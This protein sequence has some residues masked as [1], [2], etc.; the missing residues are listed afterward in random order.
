MK[1]K[2]NFFQ[3][4]KVDS[5]K[6]QSIIVEPILLCCIYGTSFNELF[7]AIQ[8]ISLSPY[9]TLKEYLFHLINYE[10]ILYK[11]QRKMYM[12]EEADLI[13]LDWITME[14]ENTTIHNYEILITLE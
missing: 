9:R 7:Q 13:R 2:I 3:N 6:L 1:I 10:L 4:K 8:R 12:I 14:K 5:P 11:G